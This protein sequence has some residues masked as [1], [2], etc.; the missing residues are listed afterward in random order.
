[1]KVGI[2][3]TEMLFSA[4]RRRSRFGIIKDVV[5]ASEYME[6]PRKLARVISRTKP[7]M[8]EARVITESTSPDFKS[9]LDFSFFD[10]INKE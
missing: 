10:M 1:M 2:K 5:K 3:A 8:R 4:K 6:V 9:D 7:I